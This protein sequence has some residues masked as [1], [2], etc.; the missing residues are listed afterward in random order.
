MRVIPPSHLPNQEP[1]GCQL[2]T[3]SVITRDYILA[4]V[5]C[6]ISQRGLGLLN[7]HFARVHQGGGR[8]SGQCSLGGSRWC[9][10]RGL[11]RGGRF[12]RRR[13]RHLYPA[14]AVIDKH[15]K[16]HR[17]H[18]CRSKRVQH[19][20]STENDYATYYV[21][22]EYDDGGDENRFEPSVFCWQDHAQSRSVRP[23]RARI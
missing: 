8:A 15:P 7:I 1:G 3:C 17:K 22:D 23:R 4:S 10:R 14:V 11:R 21:D 18:D 13:N 12:W 19:R 2:I 16:D 5:L 6:R 9:R 20:A